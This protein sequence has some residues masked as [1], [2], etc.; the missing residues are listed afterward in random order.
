MLRKLALVGAGLAVA[1]ALP[2]SALAAQQNTYKVH[3]SVT[4]KGKASGPASVKFGFDVS[5]ATGLQPSAV[6]RY[7][8]AFGGLKVNQKAF[9]T[10]SISQ[11]NGS[12]SGANPKA[13][14]GA[15]KIDNYV[16][17]DSDP[18]GVN[19]GFKCAKDIRVWNAGNGKAILFVGGDPSKCGGVGNLAPIPAKFVKSGNGQALQFEVPKT[20]LH[21]IPGLTVA[22]RSVST[23]MKKGAFTS[24]AK[25]HPDKAT[26]L[27]E[28]GQTATV[29]A[30]A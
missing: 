15:G 24:V 12:D 11:M 16:Y 28:A 19:G 17:A 13:L 22:I 26:F 10:A 30:K 18:S 25:A 5:E 6:K 21:P 8:I 27:T 23:T 7:T 2:T 29:P 20:V 1:L 9:K 3:A 14:L 4:P